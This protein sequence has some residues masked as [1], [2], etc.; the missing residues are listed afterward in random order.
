MKKSSLFS[1]SLMLLLVVVF[2]GFSPK[3]NNTP[4]PISL[5]GYVRY[6]VNIQLSP[7]ISLCHTYLVQIMNENQELALPAKVYTPG[8]S[9]Y[10]FY[11]KGPF[12]GVRAA[13][14]TQA[15]YSTF[16]C[17]QQLYTTPDVK[18]GVFMKGNTYNFLLQPKLGPQNI[19]H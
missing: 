18:Y 15:G 2:S 8:V 1:I 3:N 14:L 9:T 6:Q 19:I 7:E 13:I 16:I 4:G 17:T 10:T 11:E 5:N 12:S